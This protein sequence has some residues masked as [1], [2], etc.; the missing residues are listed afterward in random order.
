MWRPLAVGLCALVAACSSGKAENRAESAPPPTEEEKKPS[1]SID[2]PIDWS[3]C[4]LV[5]DANDYKAQCAIAHVPL[6]HADPMGATIPIALKR[7]A[8]KEKPRGTVW[9]LDGGPG[10]SATRR[11]ASLAGQLPDLVKDLDF[12]TLDH[13]GVGGS[14]RLGC[15]QED[16]T[17]EEG[18]KI[19]ENE[20]PSCILAVEQKWGPKLAHFSTTAAARDLGHLIARYQRGIQRTFVWGGSYGAYLALRYMHLFPKQPDGV[21]LEG[22]AGPDLDFTR[23][24]A[25]MNEVGKEYF[26]RCA[27]DATCSEKLGPDPFATARDV[28]TSLDEGHC[29][30]LQRS[31]ARMR[32]FLGGLLSFE[33]IRIAIAPL[34]YRTKRC[35]AADV[36]AIQNLFGFFLEGTSAPYDS[37]ALFHQVTL[38]EFWRPPGM[39]VDAAKAELATLTTATALTLD[40]ARIAPGWPAALAKPD[41]LHGKLPEF[42]KPL[43]M[44]QGGLDPQTPAKYS[45]PLRAKYTGTNQTYALFPDATHVPT[46]G[47]TTKSTQSSC[48]LSLYTQF[49]TEPSAPLDTSCVA[50]LEPISFMTQGDALALFGTSDPW[51]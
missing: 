37:E 11:L 8:A 22:I 45:E 50:D 4:S 32:S 23:H 17:S 27:A 1:P 48:A 43:L 18:A 25:D 3:S 9:L 51:D 36:T 30:A 21:I 13:R 29:K 20:W 42:D 19:T 7:I 26:A 44:L 40:V 28:V 16:A 2:D 38:A 10:S 33:S 34:V 46:S 14:E 6:D 49:V 24:S 39:T 5:P 31:S 15:P 47:T 41:D 12:I 35:S